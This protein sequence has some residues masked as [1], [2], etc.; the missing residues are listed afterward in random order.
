MNISKKLIDKY[1]IPVPRYTSYPPANH[2]RDDVNEK[3]YVE[4][5]QRSNNGKPE[6]LSFYIHIPFCIRKCP[7]CDFYSLAAE[8]HRLERDYL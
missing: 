2:F 3:D 4:L 8:S 5:I 6:Q 1:N 7:Y